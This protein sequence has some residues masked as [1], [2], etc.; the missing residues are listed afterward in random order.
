MEAQ[1][2]HE[3]W[4]RNEIG[5]HESAPNALLVKH[6]RQLSLQQGRRVFLPLCGKTRDIGWLLSQGFRVCGAELSRTAVNQLFDA[7]GLDP[8]I[9]ARGD[10]TQLSAERLDI[11]VGDIFDVSADLLGPVDAT[12]D[13]AALVALPAAMRKSYAA[14]MRQTTASAPQLLI[15]FEYDQDLMEG[16]PFSIPEDEVVALYGGHYEISKLEA[17]DVPGGLKGQC[18]ATEVAWWLRGK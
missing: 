15:C 10:L 11:F 9:E 14:H 2:W 8:T 18:A 16:P 5:F 13:R 4:R 17:V 7:L 1:F 6:F 12:Y 3:R